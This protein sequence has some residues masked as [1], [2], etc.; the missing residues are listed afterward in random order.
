MGSTNGVSTSY[1]HYQSTGKAAGYIW[2]SELCNTDGTDIVI[3][4]ECHVVQTKKGDA[5]ADPTLWGSAQATC[6]AVHGIVEIDGDDGYHLYVNEVE[7]GHAEDYTIVQGFTFEA[8]CESPTVYAIDAYDQGGIASVIASIDHCGEKI[9]TSSSWRCHQVGPSGATHYT[10]ADYCIYRNPF[11][12]TV[13]TMFDTRE[14]MCI[15]C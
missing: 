13:R 8:S 5:V 1:S 10:P 11:H 15:K 2:H 12:R 7:V 9:I 6:G 3:N 4:Q 14:Q